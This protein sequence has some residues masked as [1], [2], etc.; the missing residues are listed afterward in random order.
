MIYHGRFNAARFNVTEQPTDIIFRDIASDSAEAEIA[1]ITERITEGVPASGDISASVQLTNKVE[2]AGEAEEEVSTDSLLLPAL[3]ITLAKRRGIN[4]EPFNRQ[5]FNRTHSGEVAF[6]HVPTVLTERTGA[7]TPLAHNELRE[8]IPGTERV[9]Q[10]LEGL[11]SVYPTEAHGEGVFSASAPVLLPTL[12]IRGAWETDA[13]SDPVQI[14]NR[15]RER[16]ESGSGFNFVPPALTVR[17]PFSAEI[18]A[19]FWVEIGD[20]VPTVR[21]ALE[22]VRH[23]PGFNLLPFDGHGEGVYIVRPQTWRGDFYADRAPIHGQLDGAAHMAEELDGFVRLFLD[24]YIAGTWKDVFECSPEVWPSVPF[25]QIRI[26]R[27]GYN[28]ARFNLADYNLGIFDRYVPHRY[29]WLGTVGGKSAARIV[30]SGGAIDGERLKAILDCTGFPVAYDHFIS[31]PEIPFI[32]F[33]RA[34]SPNFHA[35]NR[36]YQRINRWEIYL[37]TEL[38]DRAAEKVL[39][40]VLDMFEIPYVCTEEYYI[41]DERLY[42]SVYEFEELED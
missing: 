36:V 22:K 23:A 25:G 35:D 6:V 28:H 32:V 1:P 3:F 26:R 40:N 2:F 13:E 38:K 21:L 5:Y 8:I 42:Q 18:G 29:T 12:P 15:V 4:Q 9:G 33:S 24:C 37:C 41:K 39:E 7:T 17:Y 14:I 20:L 11:T 16:I 10:F 27:R 34:T 19:A 30:P 31:A